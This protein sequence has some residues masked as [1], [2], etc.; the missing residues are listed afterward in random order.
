MKNLSLTLILLTALSTCFVSCSKDE[1]VLNTTTPYKNPVT[2]PS[3]SLPTKNPVKN[4]TPQD[5]ITNFFVYF[6]DTFNSSVEVGVYEDVDG[7]G[8]AEAALSAVTLKPNTYYKVSIRMQNAL[9]ATK[10]R[11]RI[12]EKIRDN[13]KD[14]RICATAPLGMN[15][16]PT[17]SDGLMAI[18]LENE[19]N[20]T[21]MK[22]EGMMNFTVRYQKGVKNGQCEAGT[23]YYKCSI[24]VFIN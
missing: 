5:T 15:I 22:G 9:D 20:T 12:Y 7:S 17:D 18:G 8:P 1:P 19:V 13:G 16:I 2:K 4:V 24:P 11:V 14:F 3:D 6:Q 10:E 21:S 23:V